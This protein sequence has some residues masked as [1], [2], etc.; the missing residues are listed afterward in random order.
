MGKCHR[1]LNIYD[2][3]HLQHLL[4]KGTSKPEIAKLLG[5]DISTIYREIKRNI[6]MF[7]RNTTVNNKYYA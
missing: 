2:R 5:F 7:R 3:V 6:H 1:Q 4:E